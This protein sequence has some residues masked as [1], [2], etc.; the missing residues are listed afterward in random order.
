MLMFVLLKEE[1]PKAAMCLLLIDTPI[2]QTLHY[3]PFQIVGTI[4][5]TILAVDCSTIQLWPDRSY[6]S[7][8][9]Y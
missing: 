8:I 5:V 1:V 2:K 4:P 7:I 9:T 3:S 6:A